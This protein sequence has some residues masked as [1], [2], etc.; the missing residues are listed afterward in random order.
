M[1]TNND[2]AP[3]SRKKTVVAK[4]TCPWEADGS[5]PQQQ[6]KKKVVVKSTCPWA[7][8]AADVSAKKENVLRQKPPAPWD[9]I[10]A[11][12]AGFGGKVQKTQKTQTSLWTNNDDAMNGRFAGSV[13]Y[14]DHSSAIRDIQVNNSVARRKNGSGGNSMQGIL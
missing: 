4:S 12:G 7:T 13:K 1:F 6:N 3:M 9:H 11:S 14:A 8:D 5:V 2:Q 10:I